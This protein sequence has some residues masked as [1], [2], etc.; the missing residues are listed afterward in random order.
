MAGSLAGMKDDWRDRLLKAIDEDGRSDRAISLA[1][2]LG[3]NFISQMRG[4]KASAPK[5]PNIEY[6]RKLAI[7]LG[8]ELSSI[9]GTAEDDSEARL[10]SA[11]LAYGVDKDY[12]E[13][14]MLAIKGFVLDVS[15]DELSQQDPDPVETSP[16]PTPGCSIHHLSRL[17]AAFLCARFGAW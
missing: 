13:P 10:R 1:A 2:G 15:D 3:V 7:V 9:V 17:R 5:K 6:V 4:T 14:A 11:L 12:I 16:A 8:K